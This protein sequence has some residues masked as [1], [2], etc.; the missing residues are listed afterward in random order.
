LAGCD[1]CVLWSE[2]EPGDELAVGIVPA[3]NAAVANMRDWKVERGDVRT[4]PGI[5]M[6]VLEFIEQHGARTVAMTDGIIGCPH[7]EGIDYEGEWCPVCEF[8]HGRDRFTAR[9]FSNL[10]R[11][12]RL[13]YRP[14]KIGLRFSMKAR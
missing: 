10:A 1:D 6:E 2:P 13:N 5:V 4:D 7:Q 12:Y 3:E 11:R 9:W 14:L 8:W